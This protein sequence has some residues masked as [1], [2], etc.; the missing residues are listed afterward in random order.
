M[1]AINVIVRIL[2]IVNVILTPVCGNFPTATVLSKVFPEVVSL[3]ITVTLQVAFFVPSAFDTVIIVVPTAFAIIF[4]F[5]TVAML[6]LLLDHTKLLSVAL[7]CK[8]VATRVSVLPTY[9][10]KEDLFNEI[11]VIG[12]T[13]GSVEEAFF[14]TDTVHVSLY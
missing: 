5:S 11:D 6:E 7:L 1:I 13:V 12:T 10:D 14:T 3:L 8:I 2:I 9:K 4:P